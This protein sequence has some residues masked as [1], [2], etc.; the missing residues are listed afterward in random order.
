MTP[1]FLN[2]CFLLS[3]ISD[4]FLLCIELTGGQNLPGYLLPLS[5][6]GIK[7]LLVLPVF[8][9]NKLAAIVAF[10]PF[11]PEAQGEEE[12]QL[13]RQIADQVAVALSNSE[14]MEE[15]KQLNWGGTQSPC[16][17]S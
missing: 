12:L 11:V 7:S 17:R 15:L 2:H 6:H 13:A 9:K 3:L 8:L 16:A 4:D 1:S 14:L 10:G 5:G